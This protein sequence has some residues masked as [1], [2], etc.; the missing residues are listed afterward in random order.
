MKPVTC[1]EIIYKEINISPIRGKRLE[2]R[3]CGRR[4]RFNVYNP[5]NGH[6]VQV[7]GVHARVWRKKAKIDVTP[8]EK[9]KQ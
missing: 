1:K 3:A 9:G 8:I 4:A 5:F 2:A 7:C 6:L